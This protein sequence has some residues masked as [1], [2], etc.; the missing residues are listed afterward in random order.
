MS[1]DIINF[2]MSFLNSMHISCVRFAPPF[3]SLAEYDKGL[4]SSVTIVP[5]DLPSLGDS[6][7]I[8]P[9]TI[10]HLT[11]RFDCTYALMTLPDTGEYM[12]TG[13]L[14]INE[15]TDAHFYPLMEKLGIPQDFHPQM[16]T[17]YNEL[18]V[19]QNSSFIFSLIN[20]LGEELY[21]EDK[22]IVHSLNSSQ[23]EVWEGFF[24]DLEFQIPKDP[25]LSVRI[26]E[27]RYENE[28][29]LL[30]YIHAGNTSGA[31]SLIGGG[32]GIL[33]D[34]LSDSLRNT[35]YLMVTMNTLMR[36]EVQYACV[37][38]IHIDSLSN[39]LVIDI[40][41]LSNACEVPVL[42][43]RMVRGYCELVRRHSL[44]GYSLQTQK[45]ITV[46]DADL[47]ADLSLKRFA[48]ELNVNSSYLSTLFK[49]DT[50]QALTDYVNSRRIERA[51]NLLRATPS[52]VQTIACS[53]GIPDVHYFGRLFRRKTNM[54]PKE[55]RKCYE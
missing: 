51:K 44:R 3:Q 7:L 20:Q 53:I 22:L 19:P 48:A 30:E 32:S 40:D 23:M 18:P 46:I 43:R 15:M 28:R 10:Y 45:I 52:T 34:R 49:S 26:L 39:S 42:I 14:L 27:N 1:A 29:R 54:T 4:R 37:H 21:G 41:K 12:L 9:D 55:Y 11:D 13:P 5:H 24:N 25:L 8:E 31:L 47:T 36:K 2:T 17:Y 50:G 35:K 16:R 6:G 33:A 38:P